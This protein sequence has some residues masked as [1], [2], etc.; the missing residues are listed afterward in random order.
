MSQAILRLPA[1]QER[2]GLRRTS[3]YGLV[4][5]G[6]FPAP[7]KLSARASGWLASEV[8]HWLEK[9]IVASRPDAKKVASPQAIAA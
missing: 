7:I 9:R 1:V 2:T 4:R 3:I 8:D 6:A 5:E